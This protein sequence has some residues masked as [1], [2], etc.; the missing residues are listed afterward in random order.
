MPKNLV[1]QPASDDLASPAW[2]VRWHRKA[3]RE[4]RVLFGLGLVI[5]HDLVAGFGGALAAACRPGGGC[6]FTFDL[7]RA[8]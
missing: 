4:Y 6:V 3:M 1:Q 5:C 7:R 2:L 8:P